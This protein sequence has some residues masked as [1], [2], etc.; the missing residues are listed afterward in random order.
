MNSFKDLCNIKTIVKYMTRKIKKM[1][2]CLMCNKYASFNNKLQNIPI[3]CKDHKI[4]NMIDVIHKKCKYD[5][6]NKIPTFGFKNTKIAYYCAEHKNNEMVNITDKKCKFDNCIIVPSFNYKNEKTPIF[7]NLHKL[8]NMINI[9]HKSC[10]Y[11][12]C[13]I[14]PTF[15][16]K[17]YKN[18]IYCKFHQLNN[19]INVTNLDKICKEGNC[20]KRAHFNYEGNI[21]ALYCSTHAKI[22]MLNIISKRCTTHDCKTRPIFNYSNLKVGIYCYLHKLD[23]MIDVVHKLCKTNLCE[24]NSR[25]DKYK[26]YCLRCYIYNFPND[27]LIRDYGTREA[28]VSQFIK[29]TYTDLNITYD[30]IIEGGCSQHRPDIFID[31]LT[32]SIIIEIDEHQHK[33]GST[34]TPEC[35][36]RRINNLF[37]DLAYRPVIFIRFNPDSYINKNKKLIKSCFEY[38]EDQG[39][40][41]A[42]KTLQTRLNKLKKIIDV[43]LNEVP[44]ENITTIKLYYDEL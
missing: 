3:Y 26:G 1:R 35:E 20:Y 42:N 9:K 22:N 2:K 25:N 18:G 37:A 14:R 21:K 29:E 12:N 23:G 39:L 6:C 38:T 16:Y 5:Q 31:C 41:K 13:K 24:M 40:P 43:N 33:K 30:K 27:K 7:C 36:L 19:M 4:T 15:N 44:T 32:H 17:E 10:N 34:Y 8:E 11:D 28:K